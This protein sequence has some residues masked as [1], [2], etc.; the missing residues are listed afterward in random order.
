M[1]DEQENSAEQPDDTDSQVNEAILQSLSEYHANNQITDEALLQ[2]DSAKQRYQNLLFSRA[3]SGKRK[4]S[5]L[6]RIV[7]PVVWV[8]VIFSMVIL[9][10][11]IS[12][13]LTG[14]RTAGGAPDI[15]AMITWIKA[16]LNT[17]R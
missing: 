2:N 1:A 16:N 6:R 17:P 14:F 10:L 5:K 12:A 15:F 7:M 9:A 4:S 3:S 8:A 13:W 11:M